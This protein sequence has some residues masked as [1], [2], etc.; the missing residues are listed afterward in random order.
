[1]SAYNNEFNY[2]DSKIRSIIVSVLGE[3][4][5]KLKIRQYTDSNEYEEFI[6]PFFYSLTGAD[7]FLLDHFMTPDYSEL[8]S[9]ELENNYEPIPRGVLTMTSLEIDAG[10]LI[11]RHVRVSIPVKVDETT[12][13]MYSYETMI[14]PV[15]L[16]FDIRIVCNS[17]IEMLKITEKL[18]SDMYKTNN[19]YV[20]F[21]GY[22]VRGSMNLPE[23][24]EREQLFEF[25][26][27]DKKQYDITF[28]VEVSTSFPVFDE[29]SEMF[30]GDRI[31]SFES[32]IFDISVDPS[33]G[34]YSNTGDG[35]VAGKEAMKYDENKNIK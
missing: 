16:S 7:D 28:S 21:G 20:D 34:M 31:E 19:F 15:N 13:K 14:V 8:S 32:N 29:K 33:Q 25:G 11:N 22:H 18:I 3:F 30:M 5:N 2:H 12:Y 1:M 10:S 26:F 27:T 9:Q 35:I 24:F 17:N 4:Q 6:V 23:S